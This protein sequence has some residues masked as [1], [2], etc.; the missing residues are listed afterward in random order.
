MVGDVNNNNVLK[1]DNNNDAKRVHWNWMDPVSRVQYSGTKTVEDFEEIK[2]QKLRLPIF[3]FKEQ[4]L[5]AVSF[6]QVN[7]YKSNF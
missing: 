4:F 2:R 6:N 7:K 5:N 3:Q 1:D